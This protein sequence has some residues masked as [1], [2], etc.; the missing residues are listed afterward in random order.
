MNHIYEVK[1]TALE[2]EC[3]R[4]RAVNAQLTAELESWHKGGVIA[5]LE[6]RVKRYREALGIVIQHQ[7]ALGAP[8]SR[9][10]EV[11]EGALAE[12]NETKDEKGL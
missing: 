1:I 4:L 9:A 5:R 2:G 3:E 6:A 8:R 7:R 12:P 11:A 10:C